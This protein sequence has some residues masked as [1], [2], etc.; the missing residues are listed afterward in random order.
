[1]KFLLAKNNFLHIMNQLL[2]ANIKDMQ[3]NIFA[4]YYRACLLGINASKVE[5]RNIL[6]SFVHYNKQIREQ[7]AYSI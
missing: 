4:L 2:L 5:L 3:F 1:M 7:D 6:I